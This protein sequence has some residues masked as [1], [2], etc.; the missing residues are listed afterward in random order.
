MNGVKEF[1]N[2]KWADAVE[3]PYYPNI[4]ER[5]LHFF[6]RHIWIKNK[7]LICNK[8]DRRMK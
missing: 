8:L 6:G 3:E 4:A 5:F 1:K 2:G 7:C